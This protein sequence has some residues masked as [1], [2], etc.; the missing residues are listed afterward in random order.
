MNLRLGRVAILLGTVA[1]L[2]A[3]GLAAPSLGRYLVVADPLKP[4]RALF[5]LE[6]STPAR[7]VEAAALYHRGYAPVVVLSLA[8]DPVDVARGLAGEPPPQERAARALH[9][10][11]V[12]DTAVVRL[13]RRV[14]NTAQELAIDYDYARRRGFDRVILVTSPSHTR[15][16]RLIW[17]HRY[18]RTI[19][20]L[21]HPT[22]YESFAADGWWRSRRDL[23]ETAHEVFGIMH[24]YLGSPLPT[25]DSDG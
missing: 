12:P 6:G 9:H 8:R 5:V 19:P 15:R 25:F 11:R 17:N 1:A 16:V 23:E 21:I 14:E 7:E 3:I 10:L 24:F 18:E 2:G 13:T 20:A 22:P 4:S